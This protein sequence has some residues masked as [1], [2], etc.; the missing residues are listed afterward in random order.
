MKKRFVIIGGGIAGLCAAIR[1]SELGEEPLLVEGGSYP[2][3]KICGEF[4]SP[5][6]LSFLHDWNIHPVPI[7]QAI[8]KTLT[9]S[10]VFPFPSPAGS[11]V[12]YSIR[13][14]V[15]QLRRRR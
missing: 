9:S 6:C 7:S 14:S 10:L 8:L 2:A 15:S 5:E 13:P 1:L 12:T 3:H 4:L 11:N